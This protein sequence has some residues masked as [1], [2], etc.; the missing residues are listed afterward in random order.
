[1]HESVADGAAALAEAEVE[2]AV[3]EAVDAEAASTS[4]EAA[5]V[6]VTRVVGVAMAELELTAPEATGV[7]GEA[8]LL[9]V[10][11]ASGLA[12]LTGADPEPPLLPLPAPQLKTAGPGMG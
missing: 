2:T 4:V 7:A 5:A 1:M 6:A 12:V 11:G 9:G 10:V 3:G 8:E